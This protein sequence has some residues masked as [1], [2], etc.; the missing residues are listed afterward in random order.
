MR[1]SKSNRQHGAPMHAN[2]QHA[3]EEMVP[4]TATQQWFVSNA[5]ESGAQKV[6]NVV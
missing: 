5:K 2:K 4:M 1:N 3:L 6:I